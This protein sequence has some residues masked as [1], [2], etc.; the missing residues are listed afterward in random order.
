MD[1]GHAVDELLEKNQKGYFDG[2][3]CGPAESKKCV[4]NGEWDLYQLLDPIRAHLRKKRWISLQ[5]LNQKAKF[6]FVVGNPNCCAE[7]HG[8]KEHNIVL[9]R[10][11]STG[12]N[13]KSY[14]R[15]D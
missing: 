8:S 15:K 10:K 14:S 3:D 4:K 2:V 5:G 9:Q 7:T 6:T 13:P 12:M 1:F 11:T